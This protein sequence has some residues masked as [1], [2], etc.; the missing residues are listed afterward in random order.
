MFTKYNGIEIPKNYSG[1]RFK[2]LS[3]VEMKTHKATV[4]SP[5]MQEIKSSASP[6]F[7]EVI[8]KTVSEL[9]ETDENIEISEPLTQISDTPA[10]IS[11]DEESNGASFPQEK[12]LH[13]E[14]GI[15]KLLDKVKQ[16]DLLLIALIILFA[17]DSSENSLDAVVILALLLLYH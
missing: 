14:L 15:L 11:V 10:C 13:R 3:D 8:D 12:A 2:S 5:P 17:S 4:S 9:K 7:Q 1:S 16:D 6:S